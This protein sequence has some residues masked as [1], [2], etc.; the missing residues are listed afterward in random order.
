MTERIA[1]L[2]ELTLSGK[3][4]VDP[5]KTGFEKEDRSLSKQEKE[6]GRL[7]AYVLNQEP[8]LTEYSCMT[9][10]FNFDGSV[11]GDA[12]RR[13]GHV[14]TQ[15]TIR[16][17]HLKPIDNLSTMEWQHATADYTKVLNKGIRGILSDIDESL[18]IHTDPEQVEFLRALKRVATALISWA[19]KCSE[20]ALAFSET[21]E[22]EEYRNNLKKLSE[23]LLRVPE[24]APETFY[25]ALL[26]IYVCFSADPDS[27]GTL[28]RYLYPFY[29]RDLKNGALTREQ[30]KE[31]LQEL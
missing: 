30:A 16:L 3:M 7:C 5:V 18:R 27:V 13:Q 28:D 24:N 6:S 15:K 25:E 2:T 4:Y 14:A 20:R 26:C 12:F 23:A 19:H 11:V 10:F 17:F 22:S 21:V 9:G 1:R 29:E 31:Y 8:K